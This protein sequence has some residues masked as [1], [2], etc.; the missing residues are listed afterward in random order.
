MKLRTLGALRLEGASLTRPKPL[1]KL[2]Y[3]ALN[4]PT[5]RRELAEVFFRD[6]D[7]PRDS[8]STS[9]RHLRKAAVVDLLPDDRIA[10]RVPCDATELLADFDAYRYEAVLATYDGPFLDGLDVELGVDLE[11]WLFGTREA[12]ARRVRSAALHRARS[13]L[14]EGRLEDARQLAAYG[15]SL[16]SAPELEVDELAA[17][18]P[19]AE[20]LGLPE[21][22]G[23]R[24]LAEGYGL[25][26]EQPSVE[27]RARPRPA[28]AETPYR[29]TAFF[30][31]EAELR[32]L[33][34]LLSDPANRLLTLFGMGGVGKTR[35]AAR[36]AERLGARGTDRFPDGVVLVPLEAIPRPEGVVPAIAARL[37]LPATAGAS[38]ATLADALAGWRALLVLDNFEHVVQAAVE[39]ALLVQSCPGLTVLV[40]SR[41]RLGLAAERTMVLDGMATRR[42]GDA[43]ADAV[44]LF[45]DRA[46]RVGY[47]A[48]AAARDA[49][50]IADLCEALEGYPLGIELAAA[51]TRVL[52]VEGIRAA[53]AEPLELLDH[54]PVDVPERHRGA[55]AAL[56]PSWVLLGEA[57]RG[58][59][60]R[61]AHF[62]AGFQFDAAN[63]V[64]G[65]SLPVLLRL[66]DHA[67]VR[68]DGTG[69]GRFG[70]HPVTRAFLRER[71]APAVQ[72]E[73]AAEHLRF[74]SELVATS[75]LRIEEEPQAVLDRLE[76]DLPDVVHAVLGA[77]EMDDPR[78]GVR[79][80][81][82]LVVGM[83][84]LQARGGA[85]DVLEV[86][87]RAA[88]VA[89][90]TEDWAVAEALW[91]KF[92]NGLRVLRNDVDGA[93]AAYECA[94][95]HAVRGGDVRREVLVRAILG[96]MLDERRPD[97]AE[98]H[99]DAAWSLALAADDP[100]MQCEVRQRWGYVAS[101]RQDWARALDHYRLAVELA[102]RSMEF[103]GAG[104][105]APS[106]QFFALLGMAGV[107][108]KVGDLDAS[109]A[110][111]ERALAFA[112]GRGQHLWAAYAHD[113]LALAHED[114]DHVSEAVAHAREAVRLYGAQGAE[115]D[116][117][118]VERFLEALEGRAV[119]SR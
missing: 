61:L 56:E 78:T 68:N 39:V 118:D 23:L 17:A 107:A 72:V 16:R 101:V 99:F 84:Y 53:L 82:E 10:S 65:V 71:L 34:E 15:L 79:M 55:R 25:D 28:V 2:A 63:A 91:T 100:V 8:L 59:L 24:E 73:A 74:F 33:E 97:E 114:L 45:L 70:F 90:T 117:A 7:D 5:T 44:R 48:D 87:R 58:A 29:N 89:E 26:P 95:G 115:A 98:R 69:R 42:V 11:D 67:F 1:L 76:A 116:R 3:L 111:R 62:R 96:A 46:E 104:A 108:A 57:E 37:A 77:L 94:L 50:A 18:L 43:P 35:L 85:P 92:A 19:L 112:L 30:G 6:A 14:A 80:A 93:I 31:R 102:E 40:T 64:A 52:S 51:M 13:A 49:D 9:L 21:G 103:E 41:V 113:E 109:V 86:A 75:A 47:S 20:R 12:I 88:T 36:L 81:H 27:R 66:V 4:G 119:A 32:Q 83:D 22:A 54:G 60:V 106:L 110:M 38:A 105:R